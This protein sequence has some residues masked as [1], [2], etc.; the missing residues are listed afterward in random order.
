M[1]D[2]STTNESVVEHPVTA[3]PVVEAAK[4]PA[5]HAYGDA[6]IQNT[7]QVGLAWHVPGAPLETVEDHLRNAAV[8]AEPVVDTEVPVPPR[9]VVSHNPVENLRSRNNIVPSGPG[10]VEDFLALVAE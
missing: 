10:S 8:R 5:P 7:T 2:P 6:P 9:D 1:P 4:L 3:D